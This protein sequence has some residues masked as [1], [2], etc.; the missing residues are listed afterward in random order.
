GPRCALIDREAWRPIAAHIDTAGILDGNTRLT[1]VPGKALAVH[2]VDAG[3]V[4]SVAGDLVALFGYLPDEPRMA[5]G[6]PAQ[7][8]ERRLH[9]RLGEQ[10]Q[11]F[12]HVTLDPIRKPAPLVACD[13]VFKC[14]HL[15]PRLNVDRQPIEDSAPSFDLRWGCDGVHWR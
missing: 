6:N 1:N 13:H 7:D 15:E 8:T 12:F 14:P 10:L 3:M 2:R 11:H 9:I 5:L 4:P